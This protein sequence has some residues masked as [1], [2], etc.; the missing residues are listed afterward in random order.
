MA[1][2]GFSLLQKKAEGKIILDM[3]VFSTE[4]CF[5]AGLLIGNDLSVVNF[6]DGPNRPNNTIIK[7]N[8]FTKGENSHVR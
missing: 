1:Q 5:V 3:A 2:S 8:H 7:R 6:A 4:R